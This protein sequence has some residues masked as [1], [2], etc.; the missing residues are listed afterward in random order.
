MSWAEEPAAPSALAMPLGSMIMM[1]APSPR[2][3]LPE[4]MSMWRSLVD[5]G[6]TTIS[7]VWNTP[8]TTM[9]KV[10]LPTCVTTMKPFSGSDEEP[11]SIFNSFFRCISGNSLLRRRNTAVSLMRSMR[12][13]ELARARTSSTTESCGI[14]TRSP[15]ASTIMA[16]AMANARGD[17]QDADG[18][19]GHG[20]RDLDGNGGAVAGHRLD[21]DGAADLVDIGSQQVPAD[22]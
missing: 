3:V 1:T 16:E 18:D 17:F 2:M 15:A 10:W 20:Q 5:I 4:N 6:L 22:P 12:C 9:P 19:D 8:S 21:V 14:A 7:S 11:S 13:S